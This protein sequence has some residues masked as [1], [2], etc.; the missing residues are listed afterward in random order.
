MVEVIGLPGQ[1]DESSLSD[2]PPE[3]VV[4]NIS[5]SISY[6]CEFFKYEKDIPEQVLIKNMD[7][8]FVK[9]FL[10]RP[11]SSGPRISTRSGA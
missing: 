5:N 4:R 10:V 8:R 2:F 1:V 7:E 3:S 6:S 11:K 9:N